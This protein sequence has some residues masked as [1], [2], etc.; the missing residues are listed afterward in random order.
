MHQSF[1]SFRHGY[2]TKHSA[3]WIHWKTFFSIWLQLGC[4]RQSPAV[5]PNTNVSSGSMESSEA[6]ISHENL[7]SPVVCGHLCFCL[8][9]HFW[10][11]SSIAVIFKSLCS[12]HLHMWICGFISDLAQR[13]NINFHAS[14]PDSTVQCPS[15]KEA[16]TGDQGR[17][18][19]MCLSTQT[20]AVTSAASKGKLH[21]C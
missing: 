2:F 14:Q 21:T 12:Y 11:T 4:L 9:V 5:I 8:F 19:W 15:P 20:S 3:D 13:D 1:F 10:T 6:W 17:A 7:G 16:R 18:S